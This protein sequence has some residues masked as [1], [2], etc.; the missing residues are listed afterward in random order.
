MEARKKKI[1]G[2][3][4][5]DIV[6]KRGTG[7]KIGFYELI[8]ERLARTEIVED[9]M[10]RGHRLEDEALELFEKETGKSIDNNLVLWTRDDNEDIGVSPDGSIGETEAVEV[11]CLASARHVEVLITQTLSSEYKMQC[12]QYFIVNEKLETLY[13]CF[14]DPRLVTKQ[15]FYLTFKREDL[16]EEIEEYLEYQRKTL[17]EVNKIVNQLTF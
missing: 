15:L 7:Q 1:T 17:E 12:I 10:E 8:A 6:V 3:R 13:F 14:Y 16:K 5:N 11:K 2:S 4:L 9:P